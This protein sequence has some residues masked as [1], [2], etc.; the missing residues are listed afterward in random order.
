[1]NIVTDTTFIYYVIVLCLTTCI[2]LPCQ[3][4]ANLLPKHLMHVICVMHIILTKKIR[5]L[6]IYGRADSFLAYWM[7]PMFIWQ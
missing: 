4:I 7:S 6:G 5:L 3:K 2:M 1:M